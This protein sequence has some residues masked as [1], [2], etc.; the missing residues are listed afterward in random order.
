MIFLAAN[1]QLAGFGFEKSPC[2]WEKLVVKYH[3][4]PYWVQTNGR[5]PAG[6]V[7][8]ADESLGGTN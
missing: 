4:I 8:R 3:P 7:G 1:L 2:N 5:V 6:Q